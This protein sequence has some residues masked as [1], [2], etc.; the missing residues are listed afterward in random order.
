M[1]YTVQELITRAYW[2]SGTVS[3]DFE[4]VSPSDID[5]G[6][7]LLNQHLSLTS[8]D[9]DKLLYYSKYEFDTVQGQEKYFIPDL[10]QAE[11]LTYNF[12]GVRWAPTDY[13]RQKYFGMMRPE[14][15]NS[16][17]AVRHIE[18]VLGGADV[19]LY[20]LPQQE[21]HFTIYGKFSF[22]EVALETDLLTIVN[23]GYTLYLTYIEAELI[24]HSKN[25]QFRD[26]AKTK[27]DE[28]SRMVVDVAPMDLSL[29]KISGLS[30]SYGPNW[31][32]VNL[33]KGMFPI[34]ASR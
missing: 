16:L 8:F 5:N 4:D 33:S 12:S 17:P 15:V 27:L 24:C 14:N 34:M 23:K 21:F 28:L 19:Y 22:P 18:L 20:Y 3:Q 26:Q 30:T 1:P 29:K 32:I 2:L 31:G 6:L 25:I 13:S 9:K 11:T 10:V 7:V